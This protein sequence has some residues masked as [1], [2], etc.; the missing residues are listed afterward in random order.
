MA[1]RVQFTTNLDKD[2]L[3][4]IKIKALVE[5]RNVNEILEQLIK[6]YLEK[7]KV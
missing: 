3:Q 2:L 4:Q 1:D 5:T 6:E 7:S